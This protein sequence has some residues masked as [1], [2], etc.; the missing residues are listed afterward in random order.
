VVLARQ[1]HRSPVDPAKRLGGNGRAVRSDGGTNSHEEAS[2]IR[3]HTLESVALEAYPK[4]A[5]DPIM[6]C[7]S[8]RSIPLGPGPKRTM[9]VKPKWVREVAHG[10][11]NAHRR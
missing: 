9:F 6:Y 11:G 8:V 4:V 5:A 3:Q 10:G 7:P 2:S 1:D